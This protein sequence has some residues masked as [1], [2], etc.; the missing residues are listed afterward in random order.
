M[1]YKP[2]DL[3]LK[4]YGGYGAGGSGGQPYDPAYCAYPV[5]GITTTHQCGRKA[6]VGIFCKQHDPIAW[7]ARRDARD[8]KWQ[9]EWA[10]DRERNR[11]EDRR[12]NSIDAF[13]TA[14]MKIAGG[15]LNDP[16]GYAAMVLEEWK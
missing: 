1:M 11:L 7:Q 5:W 3:P 12:Q 2:K 9:A 15:K 8:A 6:T 10:A 13:K 4:K 14:L 16:A